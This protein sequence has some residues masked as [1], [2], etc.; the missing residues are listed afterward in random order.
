MLLLSALEVQQAGTSKSARCGVGGGV[1]PL[2][3]VR[4]SGSQEQSAPLGAS[5][6]L[7]SHSGT[8]FVCAG[9]DLPL[10]TTLELPGIVPF[11]FGVKIKIATCSVVNTKSTPIVATVVANAGKSS[12]TAVKLL[13]ASSKR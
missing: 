2:A 4:A 8:C 3:S 9:F 1:I 6:L 12:D 11:V 7:S 5:K 10:A 13:L